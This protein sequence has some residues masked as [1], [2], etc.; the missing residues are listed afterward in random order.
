MK[1]NEYLNDVNDVYYNG[2]SQTTLWYV[3]LITAT[4]FTGISANDTAASHS[5]WSEYVDYA[6]TTRPVIDFGASSDD[7]STN[8]VTVNFTPNANTELIG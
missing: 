3:G 8:P 5:G 4:S 1:T 6:E 7:L 2:G